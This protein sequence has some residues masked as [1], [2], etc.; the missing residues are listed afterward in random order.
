MKLTC[1]DQCEDHKLVYSIAVYLKVDHHLF[2]DR[3]VSVT[4]T[5]WSYKLTMSLVGVRILLQ[6]MG[7]MMA[8]YLSVQITTKIRIDD[9]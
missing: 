8:T 5:I 2:T 7:W 4:V 9:V 3:Y 1:F 6:A